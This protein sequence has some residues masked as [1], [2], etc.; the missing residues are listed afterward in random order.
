MAA[1]LRPVPQDITLVEQAPEDVLSEAR[2]Q[3]SDILAG[4]QAEAE[5]L[6]RRAS[7]DARAQLEQ[8]QA[9]GYQQGYRAGESQA[10]LDYQARLTEAADMAA[11]LHQL[12]TRYLQEAEGEI[13]QLALAIAERFLALKLQHDDAA[14]EAVL[15]QVMQAAYGCREALLRVSP[16]DFPTLWAKRREWRQLLPGVRDF[17]I[18]EDVT[19][20]PGDLM[21]VTNQGVIDARVEVMLEQVAE[22]LGD[23]Q[24]D[25][26][27]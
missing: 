2:Q 14:L 27:N 16:A 24:G 8:A 7:E 6:L 19:L 26:E 3:A 12:D 10:K 23:D 4:A 11:K 13:V 5:A 22:Q 21:L 20:Q 1:P 18:Q 9:E 15:R 25:I 17:D